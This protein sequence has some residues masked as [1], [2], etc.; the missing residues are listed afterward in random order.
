[1][2]QSLDLVFAAHVLDRMR[3]VAP[4]VALRI[5]D[6]A[7]AL[8]LDLAEA[9]GR[10][11]A[12]DGMDVRAVR[13]ALNEGASVVATA[14]GAAVVRNPGEAAVL[15]AGTVVLVDTE[16]L[17]AESAG[18]FE[19]AAHRLA[20]EGGTIVCWLNPPAAA[21]TGEGVLA[22]FANPGP[23]T[24]LPPMVRRVGGLDAAP[25]ARSRRPGA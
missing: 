12:V 25:A 23:D 19:R 10:A 9:A 22:V 1:M 11:L 5:G 13:G 4:L 3:R 20:A 7:Q 17:D 18:T 15:P 6:L 16:G 2:T 21:P 24:V 14:A 8:E